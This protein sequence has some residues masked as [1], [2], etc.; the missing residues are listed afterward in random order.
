[1]KR[2]LILG[3]ALVGLMGCFK[4]VSTNCNYYIKPYEQA[5]KSGETEP[6]SG[7]VIA[8]AF[9]ADT[10]QY[11]VTSYVNARDGILTQK[12]SGVEVNNYICRAEFDAGLGSVVL[13]T[14]GR[15]ITLIVVDTSNQWYAW[16]M[17]E[18]EENVPN[19][20]TDLIF[21][22]WRTANYIEGAWRF[23]F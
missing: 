19:L 15:E 4:K 3:V 13:Q 8:Y 11:H 1:M 6:M 22:P 17:T 14:S 10:T 5:E 16:R 23:G 21:S 20:Y 2:I 7:G 12:G 18:I 9:R